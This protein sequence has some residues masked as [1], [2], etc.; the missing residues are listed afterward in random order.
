M[1]SEAS[2]A[3]RA[4]EA[5]PL[6][7][8][9]CAA[10]RLDPDAAR[11]LFH[12]D[13]FYDLSH[14]RVLYSPDGTLVSC[15]TVIP[16]VLRI[17][18]V[19]VPVGGVAGV[20]TLP[21]HQGR[22]Y[23]S[24]LLSQ[25]VNALA[26]EL[27][28]PLSALFPYSYAYYRRF[29]WEMASSSV[30][31]AGVSADLPRYTEASCVHPVSTR[32]DYEAVHRAHSAATQGRTVAC[33]RDARRWTV[34]ETMSAGREAFVYESANGVI[35]GYLFLERRTEAGGG[36][37]LHIIEM[38]GLSDASRRGLVGFLA[39]QDVAE[40]QW[41]ASPADLAL[42]GLFET[43]RPEAPAPRLHPEPGMMVR[44]TDLP[45]ALSRLHA[46]HL[47]PMLAEEG[48]S[49]TIRAGDALQPENRTPIRL[50]PDGVE[51]GGDTD[52]DWI[53]ANIRVLAQLYLG[54]QTPAAAASLG[55][56]SASSPDALA[57][58]DRL[59]P[60]RQP[61]VAPADQF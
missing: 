19:P 51:V 46:V 16:S 61:Y 15:L 31:W 17:G 20:A 56:L 5:E 28:Y 43:V 35:E 6:L 50:T 39:R 42:F 53:A 30:R 1:S 44:I 33:E 47:A 57:L 8:V 21:E 48:R 27:C 10:F 13:P 36:V 37:T 40:L 3:A 2:R 14:K 34:I 25:T 23:A 49:L 9:L 18:D 58:A 7:Q 24:R 55:L 32:D 52:R 54:Y 4:D 45:T 12:R 29:G 26:S 38:H 41:S 11:P 59:F 22:G 60:A